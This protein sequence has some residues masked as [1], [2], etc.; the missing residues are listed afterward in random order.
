MRSVVQRV[1][2]ARVSVD[3]E[4]IS[5]IGH[6]LMA[7]LGVEVGDTQKDAVYLADKIAKLRVFEDTEG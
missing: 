6:G 2:Y 4:K 7:L 5:E 3:G 1:S